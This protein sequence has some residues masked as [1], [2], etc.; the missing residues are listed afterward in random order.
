MSYTFLKFK[1]L[2]ETQF[3]LSIKS[4]QSDNGG[5]FKALAPHLAKHG[6]HHQFS[7][8][9][10][11]EQ[12]GRVERKIRHIVETGLAFLN[13]AFLPLKLWTYAFQIAVHLINC[14]PTPILQHM[15]PFQ[16]FFHKLPDYRFFKTLVVFVTHIY[17]H[18]HPINSFTA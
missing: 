15:C 4:L 5:E 3:N 13:T 10:T 2:V 9:Y 17:N 1:A 11:P 12:N 7:C 14:M 8:P 16:I 18:I 6:I